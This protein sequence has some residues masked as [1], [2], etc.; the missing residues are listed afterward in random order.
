MLFD[1]GQPQARVGRSYRYCVSGRR[2]RGARAA[3]VFSKQGRSTLIVSTSKAHLAGGVRPGRPAEKLAA[4][5]AQ[6]LGSGLFRKDNGD[7]F[8]VYGVKKGKVA[9]AGVAKPAVAANGASLR[10]HLNRPASSPRN[11]PTMSFVGAGR[12]LRRAGW[13]ALAAVLALALLA[14][15][16]ASAKQTRYSVANGCYGLSFGG[17]FLA[18]DGTGYAATAGKSKATGFFLKPTEL[19]VYLLHDPDRKLLADGATAA[20]QPSRSTEWTLRRSGNAF[21]SS[22]SS[23]ARRSLPVAT[24]RWRS[25]SS[26]PSAAPPYPEIGLNAKGHALA[27]RHPLRRSRGHDRRPQ[28]RRPP[29]SSSAATRTAANRGA[30]TAS[31]QRWSTAPTTIRTAP[32]RCSRTSL[33]GNPVPHPRPGRLADLQGLAG[34]ALR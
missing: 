21:A 6:P 34:A 15:P 2:N 29:T 31:P 30:A 33:Y 19:G 14:A 8:Y 3:A 18:K 24:A 1:A 13:G 27:R 7:N 28:P 5:G 22:T 23:R 11:P 10:K 25:R 32:A 12:G 4:E 16:A 17:K 26:P 9:F 20:D